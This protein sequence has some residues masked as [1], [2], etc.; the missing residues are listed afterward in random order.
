MMRIPALTRAVLALVFGIASYTSAQ[1]AAATSQAS[2]AGNGPPAPAPLSNVASNEQ[3]G[4]DIDRF[5]GD[6]ANTPVH[7]THGT[8]RT[9]AILTPG[10]P[11]QPGPN[12]A[13][14]E[15]RKLL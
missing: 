10:N 7:L 2:Q 5:L 6:P 9:H 14:L 15:Y 1:T 11:Y 8:I 12:A 13:V 3:L 4:F